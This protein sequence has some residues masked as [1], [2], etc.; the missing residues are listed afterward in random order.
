MGDPSLQGPCLCFC[1]FSELPTWAVQ[2]HSPAPTGVAEG[3]QGS[4]ELTP[5][6][7]IP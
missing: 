6:L 4:W 2:A 3:G 1:P 7:C 5:A